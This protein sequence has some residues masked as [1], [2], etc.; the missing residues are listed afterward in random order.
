MSSTG[1]LS[2]LWVR[3]RL[4]V[5]RHRSVSGDEWPHSSYTFDLPSSSTTS[6][7]KMSSTKLP[8]LFTPFKVGNMQLQHRVVLAP[9]SRLRADEAHAHT[10]IAVE[11]YSQRGSTPGTLLVTEATPISLQ[12]GIFPSMPGIYDDGQIAAWKKVTEA[13]HAKGSFIFL[14]LGAMGRAAIPGGPFEVVGASAIPIAEGRAVPR[15]LAI[16]EIKQ[17]LQQYARAAKDAMKAGFDGV[18]ILAANGFLVDQF[19]QS[20]SNQRTDAYGGSP[21]NRIRFAAEIIDAVASAIGP[22]RVAMRFSP[23]S[24]FQGMRMPDPIPTFSALIKHLIEHQPRLA[25]LH[26]IQPRISANTDAEPLT[27]DESNDFA[28]ELWSPRP[29]ILAG[30]FDRETAIEEAEKGEK[31]TL[32]AVGRH[33]TSNPDLPKR[34]MLDTVLTPYDRSTFYSKGAKGY[35]DWA[36][37]QE[38]LQ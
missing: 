21:E 35:S 29:L 38:I 9:L 25:Y 4:P 5:L 3:C 8:T 14:Q 2:R 18:E 20:N 13:V 31:N 15:P 16:E 19:L 27:D 33:F 12:A 17:Y 7:S 22:E 34:W 11:Y 24:T 37:S 36:F 10:D 26:F 6:T 1:R 32:V 23:W 30:G 28:R